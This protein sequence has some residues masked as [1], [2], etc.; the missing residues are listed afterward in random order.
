M[1]NINWQLFHHPHGG[2]FLRGH[3]RTDFCREFRACFALIVHGGF[4]DRNYLLYTERPNAHHGCSQHF[5]NFFC[6]NFQWYRSNGAFHRVNNV[7]YTSFYPYISCRIQMPHI[8]GAVPRAGF[9]L[10]GRTSRRLCLPQAVVP[11]G[12]PWCRRQNFTCNTCCQRHDLL[13]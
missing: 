11:V 4:H 5:R 1:S 7:H 2:Y 10:T 6:C 3:G 13:P 9:T 12:H 8:A